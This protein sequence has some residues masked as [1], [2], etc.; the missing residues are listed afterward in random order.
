[1]AFKTGTRSG[2]SLESPESLFSDI[3]T[4]QISSPWVG[5]ADVWR[6]YVNNAQQQRDVAFQIPTGGGKT[7]VGIV[8]AEWWRRKNNEQVVFLCPTRQ[9]VNQVAELSREHYGIPAIAFTGRKLDY[10]PNDRAAYLNAESIAITTYSSLFNIKPFFASPHRIILDDAHAAEQYISK[11]WQI[12]IS[13]QEDEQLFETL[14]L[15]LKG[16]ITAS[17]YQQ[18]IK[19]S[20]DIGDYGWIQMLP[21]PSFHAIQDDIRSHIDSLSHASSIRYSW[22]VVREHLDACHLYYSYGEILIR[23]LLSPT[24]THAPFAGANQRLYMSATLGQGGEL[25]RIAGVKNIHRIE[26]NDGIDK[27]LIG[28]RYFIFPERSLTVSEAHDSTVKLIEE[29]NRALVISPSQYRGNL[30]ASKIQAELVVPFYSAQDL[31]G[32]KAEF[33]GQDKAVALVTNRY[34]GV[35]FPEDECRLLVLDALP[36]AMNLQERFLISRM[37]CKAV[38]SERISTRL[39]QAF[40]RCTRSN[41]D[42]SGVVILGD[43]LNRQLMQPQ[44]RQ[45]LPAELQSEIQFGLENAKDATIDG[46]VDNFKLFLAQGPDWNEANEFIVAERDKLTREPIPGSS[47]LES[48]AKLEIRYQ[49]AMWNGDHLSAINCATQIVQQLQDPILRGFRTLWHYLAGSAALLIH[50]KDIK[51]GYDQAARE[52]FEQAAKANASIVWLHELARIGLVVDDEAAKRCESDVL[53]QLT[54]ISQKFD[55]LGTSNNRAFNEHIGFVTTLIN[56][57]NSKKFEEGQRLLGLL[58]GFESENVETQGA[59]DPWWH[60]PGLGCLVFEDFT[61]AKDTSLLSIAKARQVSGHPNWIQSNTDIDDETPIIPVLISS[62]RLYH[63][64]AIPHLQDVCFWHVDDFRAWAIQALDALA[65]MRLSSHAA[66]DLLWQS[67]AITGMQEASMTL[68]S[69]VNC[70]QNSKALDVMTPQ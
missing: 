65:E 43:D 57:D 41:H 16:K 17:D 30:L 46:H 66:N 1:M 55:E 38:F 12:R 36:Q 61:E 5:Q 56:D 18:L 69:L 31:E 37:G 59:P 19:Q 49:E 35:N 67:T 10:T 3:K 2:L 70:M 39:I 40:G 53:T 51:A 25:E 50:E 62:S 26:T 11:L 13:K 22:S 68:M 34:D 24:S 42:Y 63:K 20:K 23:P 21:S 44:T 52:S 4:K 54:A 6:D 7:L 64:D 45:L 8:L 9:L 48:T 14:C 32:S 33:I 58:L 47:E 15:A 29:A 28:R 60:A 27:Q